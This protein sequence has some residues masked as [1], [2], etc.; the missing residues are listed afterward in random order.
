MSFDIAKLEDHI[1]RLRVGDTLTENEVKALCE[2][3][4]YTIVVLVFKI[5][6]YRGR[7]PYNEAIGV[8]GVSGFY[9][10]FRVTLIARY[11][12]NHFICLSRRV[13]FC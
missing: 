2:K 9:V 5:S 3:V 10:L 7:T 8:C 6:I 12:M 1:E 4:R 13:C 11:I